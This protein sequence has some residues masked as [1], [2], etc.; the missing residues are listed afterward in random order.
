LVAFGGLLLDKFTGFGDATYEANKTVAVAF[1][2]D[3]GDLIFGIL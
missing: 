2:W 3:S 1:R